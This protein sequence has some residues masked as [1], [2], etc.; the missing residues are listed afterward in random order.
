[1]K[2]KLSDAAKAM[3]IIIE[4]KISGYAYPRNGNAHNPTPKYRYEAVLN[5]KLIDTSYRARGAIESANAFALS[6]S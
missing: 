2:A 3:G 4:R 1:M 5:G 6:P